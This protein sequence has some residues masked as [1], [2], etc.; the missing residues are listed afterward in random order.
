MNSTLSVDDYEITS[1][2][3]GSGR[4]GSVILAYDRRN[5]SDYASSITSDLSGSTIAPSTISFASGTK[6]LPGS[7]LAPSSSLYPS[8]I[9][10]PK[11]ILAVK[12]IKHTGTGSREY[13]DAV[14]QAG[15]L[16]ML[17]QRRCP[18]IVDFVGIVHPSDSCVDLILS[19]CGRENL[20]QRALRDS[21]AYRNSGDRST[22]TPGG[23]I[24]SP[25]RTPK[26]REHYVKGI[27]R[28]LVQAVAGMHEHHIV[29]LDIKP[30]NIMID[31]RGH[32]TL[33]DFGS[34]RHVASE[35]LILP[36]DFTLQ[37]L[38]PEGVYWTSIHRT[39]Q[40]T[41]PVG[42]P[43]LVLRLPMTHRCLLKALDVWA[44]GVVTYS[45]LAFRHPFDP[46]PSFSPPELETW[47]L[48]LEGERAIRP[49][50]AGGKAWEFLK[51]SMRSDQSRIL[52]LLQG[53]SIGSASP[54]TPTGKGLARPT[55]QELARMR[56]LSSR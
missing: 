25:V 27:I 7:S 12:R 46:P 33:V 10:S 2:Q 28:Q 1:D 15:I 48:S 23:Q 32:V 39:A 8:S 36:L 26:E 11:R 13:L 24:I 3:L 31:A 56:W 5:A 54:M 14:R 42:S 9:S 4:E 18:N 22:H 38:A 55:I 29:H 34:A 50:T 17:K 35:D 51:A 6:T 20:I 52:G 21:Q 43:E 53:G 47:L 16:L 45:L 19:A 41:H 40:V 30:E 49:P 44:V 37:Y